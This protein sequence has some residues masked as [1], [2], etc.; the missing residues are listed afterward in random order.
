M[1]AIGIVS[2]TPHLSAH[3]TTALPT[4]GRDVERLESRMEAV[5]SE[6]VMLKFKY[7]R[8]KSQLDKSGASTTR[9][10]RR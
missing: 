2:H 4:R 6:L 8:A 9:K 10:L 1:R 7:M 3:L 5:N